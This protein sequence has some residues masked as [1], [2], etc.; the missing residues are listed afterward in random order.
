M[1]FKTPELTPEMLRKLVALD[2]L[3]EKLGEEI[4]TFGPWLGTLRR[5]VK[6]NSVESSVSIEGYSV[7]HAD[8]VALVA[9]EKAAPSDDENRMAVACYA[10][11]M[12]HVGVLAADPNFK[13]LDRVILDLHFDACYFQRDKSPGH[14]RTT[15]IGVTSK[16]GP[17]LAYEGPP[18]E[19]VVDLM[20]EVVRWLEAGDIDSHPVVRA[21]MAHLHVVSVHPFRD[22]NGRISRIVQSLVLARDQLVSP[23]FGSIEDY[24]ASRTPEYYAALGQVQGGAYNP[25][26]D[27]SSWVEFCL[28]AHLEQATKRLAQINEAADRWGALEQ[29]AEEKGWPDR[30]VVAMEQSL[31]GG[32]DRMSYSEEADISPAT[33]SADFRRLTDAGLVCPGGQRSQ[34]PV[35]RQ[36]RAERRNTSCLS[37]DACVIGREVAASQGRFA[38]FVL[39]VSEQMWRSPLAS[40]AATRMNVSEVRRSAARSR[41]SSRSERRTS[42]ADVALQPRRPIA[43]TRRQL[44]PQARA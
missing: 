25:E 38:L 20:D 11:A 6:A 41:S 10:R 5:E 28:D 23:E 33:A 4:T 29:I 34:H 31:I 2:E 42:P 13:W 22:G 24:L 3:R 16:S 21:A 37:D 19:A 14:W 40:R 8:A 35:F 26:R 9:G 39:R 44:S 18:G 15:P 7:P 12:D 17:G 32:A 43:R 1:L 36:R 30:L 27:A